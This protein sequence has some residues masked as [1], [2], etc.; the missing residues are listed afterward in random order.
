MSGDNTVKISSAEVQAVRWIERILTPLIIAAIIALS[1]CS[2]NSRDDMMGLKN[3]VIN[4]S[5]QAAEA[6]LAVTEFQKAQDTMLSNQHALEVK[7]KAAETHQLYIK[8]ELAGVKFQNTEI[9]KILRR[10]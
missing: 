10:E 2:I 8:E 6:R 5:G 9:L 3:S 4:L 7:L 1:T